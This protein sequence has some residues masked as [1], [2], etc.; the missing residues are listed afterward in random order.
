VLRRYQTDSVDPAAE[1]STL[2]GTT[3][4][5]Q[6]PNEP[7][8]GYSQGPT[9]GKCQGITPIA[10][11]LRCPLALETP[12]AQ[13]E[14]VMEFI[15]SILAPA[16]PPGI[17]KSRWHT[18]VIHASG[19]IG[20]SSRIRAKSSASTRLAVCSDGHATCTCV[21][22]ILELNVNQ[23]LVS[24]AQRGRRMQSTINFGTK[25]PEYLFFDGDVVVG[26][27]PAEAVTDV[28]CDAEDYTE[29][30]V[31]PAAVAASASNAADVSLD[32]VY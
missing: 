11:A 22:E 28:A 27:A 16:D 4:E 32:H 3:K 7:K 1:R 30:T 19:A 17:D 13:N 5:A 24:N 8:G 21:E 14:I 10:L 15:G 12:I 23:A 25:Y 26:F 18:V 20:F 2:A 6:D 31:E 9:A 29:I